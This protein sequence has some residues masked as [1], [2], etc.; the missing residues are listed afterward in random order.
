MNC[1]YVYILFRPDGSPCYLGKGKGKRWLHHE[2]G[3]NKNNRHLNGIIARAKAQGRELPKIKVR[4]HLSEAEA[5]EVEKALIAAIGREPVGPLVNLT[6]GGD[7]TIN[8]A[9]E[10]RAV[11]SEKAKVRA[12]T[13]EVRA[14]MAA[15][16]RS[17]KGKRKTEAQRQAM[18]LR[19]IGKQPSPD[20]C[21]A[22]SAALKKRANDPAI[23]TILINQ[24]PKGCPGPIADV[25]R[26]GIRRGNTAYWE[27]RRQEGDTSR[28]RP[29]GPYPNA[30]AA[31]K[32]FHEK[33]LA[34][35]RHD[36][37]KGT[38]IIIIDGVA[39][40]LADA[41]RLKGVPH[42]RVRTRIKRGMAPISALEMG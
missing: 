18:S 5:F 7:G 22:I 19:K 24:L 17:G 42:E 10:V 37:N 1:F 41:C 36:I 9:P 6:D 30:S 11:M 14:R 35:G 40:S 3:L 8:I 2:R 28:P 31:I 25:R 23:K 12:R 32:A 33:R 21:A 34:E 38:R 29:N 27:R 15:L 16:G 20:H 26:E 39:M 13:P 4:E